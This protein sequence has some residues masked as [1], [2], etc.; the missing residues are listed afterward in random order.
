MTINQ[1]QLD[2]IL[3]DLRNDRIHT[4]D[5]AFKG[6]TTEQAIQIAE[7][8]KTNTTLTNLNLGSN[9]IGDEGARAIAD[10]LQTNTR[11]IS[12][13][14]EFNQIGAAGARAIADALQTNTTMTH[15]GLDPDLKIRKTSNPL[16]DSLLNSLERTHRQ[17]TILDLGQNQISQEIL[18]EINGYLALNRELDEALK[19]KGAIAEHLPP[20]IA[21]L[22]MKHKVNSEI[23]SKMKSAEQRL[24]EGERSRE[25]RRPRFG[26][27]ENDMGEGGA[28]EPSGEHTEEEMR[29]AIAASLSPPSPSQESSPSYSSSSS[30]SSSSISS[31]SSSSSSYPS[32]SSSSSSSSSS[33]PS[34]SSFRTTNQIH[35]VNSDTPTE[36][37]M[38]RQAIAASLLPPASPSREIPE[39]ETPSTTPQ[40]PKA[41][42][43]KGE[44]MGVRK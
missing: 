15:L 39:S 17:I 38:M 3:S 10:A 35:F 25:E 42:S 36:A 26:S 20:D 16:L 19:V 12:L 13:N 9:Q 6:L 40:S 7:A 27:V 44:E 14:L 30:S 18:A 24:R 41:D 5:L 32:Y 43:V 2:Q 22:I 33:S 1:E 28:N 37:E 34:S 29:Q 21:D 31:S 4:L 23:A 11:L 8:L